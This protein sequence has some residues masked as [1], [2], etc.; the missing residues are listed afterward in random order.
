[1]S[2]ELHRLGVVTRDTMSMSVARYYRGVLFLNENY[3]DSALFHFR[4]AMR[5]FMSQEDSL[6]MAKSYHA[7][8]H[9]YHNS[10]VEF[11]ISNY[12]DASKLYELIGDELGL[13]SVYEDVADIYISDGEYLKGLLNLQRAERLNHKNNINCDAHLFFELG[14]SH[15]EVQEYHTALDYFM[16]SKTCSEVDESRRIETFIWISRIQRKLEKIEESSLYL[17][18]A[19]FE[20]SKIPNYDSSFYHLEKGNLL[21]AKSQFAQAKVA[22]KIS[23]NSFKDNKNIKETIKVLRKLAALEKRSQNLRKSIEYMELAET[24]GDSLYHDQDQAY[25][26]SLESKHELQAMEREINYLEK[27][28]ELEVEELKGVRRLVAFSWGLLALMA[29]IIFLIYNFYRIKRNA[30]TSLQV[31]KAI[32]EKQNKRIISSINYAKHIQE[33]ILPDI[34]TWESYFPDFFVLYEPKDIV[35]GDFYWSTGIGDDIFISAI[36]CTGHGV[37]GAFLSLISNNFINEI[38]KHEGN[39]DT[40]NI[41]AVM[42]DYLADYWSNNNE[43]SYDGMDISIIRYNKKTKLLEFSGSM[44]QLYIIKGKDIKVLQGDYISIGQKSQAKVQFTKQNIQLYGDEM[45]YMFTDGYME[46]FGGLKKKKMGGKM[47]KLYL[48]EIS[49]YSCSE[50][51]ALLLNKFESWRGPR[52][53][54]DDL[55]ILGLR[56]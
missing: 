49:K 39:H 15:F 17:D 42:H 30:A 34:R 18:S 14:K 2:E 19:H 36:D 33:S 16:R 22:Y 35:S 38:I 52:E 51:R 4:V 41:L 21:V 11:A 24:Y 9:C 29:I 7:V 48:L 12:L 46:Q 56:I 10:S 47:F 27:Q 8:A 26:V 53:Q 37:P 31:Q 40:D 55:T 1:S 3:L 23:F 44:H 6:W 20:M 50:Q 32:V 13:A 25:K 5:Y 43:R 28:N 45:L 54:N